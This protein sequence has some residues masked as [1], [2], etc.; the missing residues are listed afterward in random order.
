[1]SP[2]KNGQIIFNEAP[3]PGPLV[4]GK[5]MIYKEQAIDTDTI[6]LDGGFLVKVLYLSIDPVIRGRMSAPPGW[7]YA[8]GKP[9]INYGL[10][11]VLRSEH[12]SFKVGNLV[13]GMMSFEEYAICPAAQAGRFSVV[14]NSI[15]LA[16]WLGPVG[17]AGETAY[18]GWKE[19]APSSLKEQAALAPWSIQLAKRDGMK[20][21]ASA[22]SEEKVTLM[23]QYGANV[24]F[25]YKTTATKD[26]LA[27]EGPIDVYWDNVGGETLEAS[28]TAAA[29][30]AHFIECGMVSGYEGQT[31]GVKNLFLTIP[32]SIQMHGFVVSNLV[33]KWGAEFREVLP[34]LIAS[35]EIKYNVEVV[36]GLEKA[37]ETLTGQMSGKITG[38]P[39]IQVATE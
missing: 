4:L 20:V 15:P 21:I 18:Y 37:E 14:D 38:K 33:S 13:Y 2:V 25:N 36:K 26:V 34:K 22:G 39:V 5:S 31:Y 30:F 28:I 7:G 6:V 35:G 32:K 12:S 17:L 3:G 1:M 27:K 8:A 16:A 24:A 29:P 19:Y 10:G 9:I 23:K 11:R